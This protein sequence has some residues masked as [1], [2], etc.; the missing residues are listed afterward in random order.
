MIIIIFGPPGV[1]KGTISTMIKAKYDIPHISSGNIIREAIHKNGK[2]SLE[3]KPFLERGQLVP[4]AIAINIIKER[5]ANDDC[6]NGYILDG[7]PRTIPQAEFLDRVLDE[8]TLKIN[9][10]LNL[11]ASDNVIIERLSGRRICKNCDAIYHI[12]NLKPKKSGICNKCGGVLFQ[13]EDDKPSTIRERIQVYHQ[14]TI[15]L[16]DFYRVR[17]ILIDIYTEKSLDEIFEDVTKKLG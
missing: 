12:K 4:D 8:Q 1:G 7:F 16:I 14:Q 3:L 13:R 5:V 17:K 11:T 15:P 6:K 2:F 9:Y 10:V